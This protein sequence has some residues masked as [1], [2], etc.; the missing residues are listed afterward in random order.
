MQDHDSTETPTRKRR[1]VRRGAIAAAVALCCVIGIGTAFAATNA[2]SPQ[3]AADSSS[4]AG[5]SIQTVAAD[6]P[7]ATADGDEAAAAPEAA[8]Q[9]DGI[10]TLD[11]PAV[12]DGDSEQTENSVC[13]LVKDGE[14]DATYYDTI[15]EAL[16]AVEDSETYIITLVKDE[17]TEDV[18]IGSDKVIMLN[19]NGCTLTDDG[20]EKA[21]D[22][23]GSYKATVVNEGT[24]TI[25]DSSDEGDGTI[26]AVTHQC[27]ALSNDID[28]ECN[29]EAGNLT[30]SLEAGTSSDNNGGNSYYT[31]CNEGTMTIGE[32]EA[33][34]E[35][36]N[37]CNNGV[38]SSAIENGFYNGKT[39]DI[40]GKA[41]TLTI[42]SGTFIGGKYTVKSD[43][44]SV[45]VINGGHFTNTAESAG[46]ILSWNDTTVNG[47]TFHATNC[48]FVEPQSSAAADEMDS[49]SIAVTGG[50]FVSDAGTIFGHTSGVSDEDLLTEIGVTGGNFY[51]WDSETQT[52]SRAD[53]SEYVPDGYAQGPDGS[54]IEDPVCEISTDEGTIG[55]ESIADALNDAA[56]GSTVKLLA[57]V[58]ESVL[59]GSD[60]DLTL[61]LN[62]CTL[63]SDHQEKGEGDDNIYK[64]T[65][66]NEG[67]LTITDTSEEAD[68][69][70]DNQ[71]NQRA[72]LSNANG[73]TCDIEHGF[74]TRSQE[75]GT[76]TSINGNGYWTVCNQGVMTVG[77]A[78]SEP[79]D[80][81]DPDSY[82]PNV[83]MYNAGTWATVVLNG[84]S[85]TDYYPEGAS[86]I[87][88]TINNDV[89]VYGGK[90][91]F[92]TDSYA[93]TTIE[94]GVFYNEGKDCVYGY[95]DTTVN[96]GYFY[97]GGDAVINAAGIDSSVTAEGAQD[98][99]MQINGGTFVAFGE[100]TQMVTTGE[101]ATFEITGGEYTDAE[102]NRVDVS[103]Y[104]PDGYTQD[105]D[106][107]IIDDAVCELEAASS[108][109]KT[110]Y[111][112]I[113]DAL[114]AA[115]TGDTVKL[116]ADVTESVLIGSDKD[117]TLDLNSCTLSSDH[118][119][120]GE[121]D[122]N[123]YKATVVN[124]GKLTI[125]DTS[126]EADGTIDNQ[127][128]QRAAL[129]NANGAT[130][131]I[132][133]GFFTRSQE[134]GTETSINGNGYWTVCNQGVMTVGSAESEPFDPTDPDSYDP[135]VIMYNAGTWATVVLNGF[136]NTDYYPEGASDISLTINN[137]V[138]VYGGKHC[139]KTDSYAKTTIEGG[140]FYN[141]GKDCVYGYNDTTV[142][143]GYFYG[144]GDA[145]INAAGIDSSVTAEGAQDGKMQINGGT[146][147]AFGE[148]TQMVT[149]G[150]DATFEITGGE[151]TDAEG[152]RVDVSEYL[153]DG[154]AQ[155]KDGKIVDAKT[156]DDVTFT[157]TPASDTYTGSVIDVTV[158]GT[159]TD[160]EALVEG[161][162]Y[163]WTVDPTEVKDAGTYTVAITGIY[164]YAGS[165]ATATFEIK[166]AAITEDMFTV[167]TS[168]QTYTGSAITP[169]VTSTLQAS[170][171]TVAYSN[172]TEVGQATITI[173]GQ[174]NC[175]GTL[176]YH[177]NIVQGATPE[178]IAALKDDVTSAQ[179]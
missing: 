169:S 87:S 13:K 106:G 53:V 140:V 109:E 10:T 60:K 119:E 58:T 159:D 69:T 94:G 17:I 146:F 149:T 89:V 157:V 96:G 102:G 75:C 174:G 62:S 84:F 16:E 42:N 148:D 73:A 136:S 39:E 80:P 68:G 176:T 162:D 116:L 104:L 78:E 167:D 143:G 30:R 171:Y 44:Y 173:T 128:N 32:E 121:G 14:V 56:E 145:V 100:D 135:N 70:I 55:Y 156:F 48:V 134:C 57:D 166:Q 168:D 88:L 160:G 47:G 126:E 1:S 85:N 20:N 64:A 63:S 155:D 61:D 82:D 142:N 46:C 124:E 49:G 127:Y 114:E 118:Q 28:A 178:E 38:Y 110:G 9:N 97:G 4:A 137:D 22:T 92:K 164:V 175:T 41:A 45:L 31:I 29:I 112:S 71:Y 101:D 24:L 115:E 76:E 23:T 77:S 37:I 5:S 59:I 165:T 86:D 105:A 6:N 131:D 123:I 33:D 25:T 67:K 150:E 138:V 72:A 139:F 66:V 40:E 21:E 12:I 98:G 170:D 65:V 83:I 153:P 147:V 152:N 36:I 130:C 19:L 141:E 11:A 161:T 35:L 177:F 111:E 107:K 122:D 2:A 154:Y 125:T 91:C 133:H 74:F 7:A 3:G 151:Y 90:H 15:A 54:I 99:K 120:K 26:D 81:T 108:G 95:N 117:L 129:S 103:E 163:T 50:T 93:K 34:D 158:S 172:N 52:A 132:E 179:A 51:A 8:A 79:F 43:D 18:R 27:A 144:G 113:A